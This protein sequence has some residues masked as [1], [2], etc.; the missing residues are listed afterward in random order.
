MKTP[1]TTQEVVRALTFRTVKSGA[2]LPAA[3]RPHSA[4]KQERHLGD[5]SDMV[6]IGRRDH[7]ARSYA[8]YLYRLDNGLPM[9][10]EN[11]T[12]LA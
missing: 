8:R 7:A 12:T 10:G 1:H 4:T 11:D 3:S 5:R 9:K 2:S 6:A